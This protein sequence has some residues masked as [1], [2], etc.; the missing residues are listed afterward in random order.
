VNS[1][2]ARFRALV[3]AAGLAFAASASLPAIAA[4]DPKVP[5]GLDPGGLAI[6]LIGD[7]VDYTDPEIAAR[8]ARDGEGEP[9]ALDLVDG[10]V[11][12]YAPSNT[13]RG[14]QLAKLLLSTYNNSRL[15]VVRADP[16]DPAS[17]ARAA[18]F[19]SRTPSRI[20][21]VVHWGQQE[22]V[23]LPFSQAAG[24]SGHVLFVVPGGD[25]GAR[26]TAR[27]FPAQLRIA[28][29]ISAAPFD[30]P[31][32]QYAPPEWKDEVD[33]WVVGAGA[34]M[35]GIGHAKG[36]RD[37]VEAAMLVAGQAACALHGAAAGEPPTAASLKETVLKQARTINTN[38]KSVR[39]HDPM[40]LYGGVLFG[41]QGARN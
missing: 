2:A 35:F 34:T 37:S 19:V 14:T 40:C 10:D 23:W 28:N 29:A 17:L 22:D 41:G 25:E 18:V 30:P 3:I 6:A 7:G 11:R 16:N 36:P 26:S 13:G 15:V 1:R 33:A 12:P 4:Q 9:I 27:N 20:A 21:A 8:L 31:D 5:H 39:V 32:D 38:G 24:Q